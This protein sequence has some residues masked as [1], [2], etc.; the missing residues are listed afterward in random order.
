MPQQ[1]LLHRIP[2]LLS[3]RGGIAQLAL[4][5]LRRLADGRALRVRSTHADWG[6]RE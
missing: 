5:R 1:G 2:G 4:R 3:E 6:E